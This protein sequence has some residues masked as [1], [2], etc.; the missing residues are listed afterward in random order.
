MKGNEANYGRSICNEGPDA[1]WISILARNQNNYRIWKKTVVKERNQHR[2]MLCLVAIL[3][4]AADIH[5]N[6]FQH[7]L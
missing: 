7:M 1:T 6:L 2:K 5:V 3:L 4:S